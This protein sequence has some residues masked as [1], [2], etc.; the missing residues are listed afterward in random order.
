MCRIFQKTYLIKGKKL[1]AK[2][3]DL[4]MLKER[5]LYDLVIQTY[6]ELVKVLVNMTEKLSP[7]SAPPLVNMVP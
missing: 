5:T 2:Q 7:C 6:A 3:M 4:E 1:Q